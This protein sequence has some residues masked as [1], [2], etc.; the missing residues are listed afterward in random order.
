MGK[1]VSY[2]AL[3]RVA[4]RTC[5][6]KEPWHACKLVVRKTG[7]PRSGR[8][9]S[10]VGPVEEGLWPKLNMHANG[11]SDEGVVSMKRA[12]NDASN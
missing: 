5:G 1:A 6:V 12:N 11:K 7:D 2:A 4:A 8:P 10:V 9:L 3:S